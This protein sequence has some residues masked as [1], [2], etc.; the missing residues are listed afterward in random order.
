MLWPQLRARETE[1]QVRPLVQAL[2]QRD[3]GA[4][5]PRYL[6]AVLTSVGS[7]SFDETGRIADHTELT[8][9]V[10]DG[11]RHLY[12]AK[13]RAEL[14]CL[15]TTGVCTPETQRAIVALSVVVH[16]SMHLRGQFDEALTECES[17]GESGT[18]SRVLGIPLEQ[19]RMISYLHYKALNPNT[20]PEYRI[21]AGTCANAAAL[22]AAPPGAPGTREALTAQIA[23]AWRDVAS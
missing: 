5:C 16:E 11:L 1:R 4:R 18:V 13:G 20:P 23:L 6:T 8:G 9:P 2:A 14:S 17:L 21:T 12:S 10:C 15:T 7:V 3:A 22:D 19:A